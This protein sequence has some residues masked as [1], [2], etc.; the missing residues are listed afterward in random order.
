MHLLVRAAL[1]VGVVLSG[2]T[3]LDTA[4]AVTG[5]TPAASGGATGERGVVDRATPRG[6]HGVDRRFR[7]TSITVRQVIGA[8]RVLAQGRDRRGVPKPPPL[9]SRGKWQ[10]AWDKT[11]RP[12]TRHGV[13]RLTAHTYPR[14]AG[15]ALGNRLLDRLHEDAVLVVAGARRGE[16]LCYRVTRRRSVAAGSAVRAYYSSGGPARLAILVCSGV[17]RG[18]GD[19]SRRTIWFASPIDVGVQEPVSSSG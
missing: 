8:T 6:C 5:T 1:V 4:S 19:W 16:R 17:R 2:A 11:V 18:P 15:V 12:G 10:F 7:P 3:P 9:T 13:V 14:W